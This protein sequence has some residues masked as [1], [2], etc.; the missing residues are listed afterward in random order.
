MSGP[1][2]G[3]MGQMNGNRRPNNMSRMYHHDNR[4]NS[5]QDH[6]NHRQSYQEHRQSSHDGRHD[7][8]HDYRSHDRPLQHQHHHHHQ[9]TGNGQHDEL[10]KYIYDSWNKVEMEKG[11]NNIVY[12]QD[13]ESSHLKDF[14]PFDLEAYWGRRLHQ[15]HHQQ[16]LS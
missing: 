15:N 11:S 1:R 14:R 5:Y 9:S 12:Y 10:I 4:Q 7:S 2:M 16:H 13:V 6:S 3:N 8:R